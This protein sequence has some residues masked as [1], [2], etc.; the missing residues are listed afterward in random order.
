MTKQLKPIFLNSLTPPSIFT[1]ICLS[2]IGALAM[3]IFLP[4]LPSMAKTFGVTYATATLTITLF[5]AMNAVFQL[6]VGPLSDRFGRRPVVLASLIIF[7]LSSFGCILA[8]S[9]ET[10]LIC[11]LLQ[12]VVVAG[13]VL[14][15]AAIRDMHSQDQAASV[16][17]YV[18]MGMAILPLI[19]P[20]VGGGLEVQFGWIAS[21]WVLFGIGV[22]VFL[23]AYLDMGETNLKLI[24]SSSVPVVFG[25]IAS[26]RHLA[27]APILLT[28]V[29]L[30]L[31]G[32]KYLGSPQPN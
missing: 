1:L 18:T 22:L 14:S 6:F 31:L 28:L 29:V 16:L 7:C 3:N 8:P 25:A 2:A 5:L 21:F 30:P 19:G 32:V 10:F 15:R 26:R 9:F 23:L 20:A 17:G 11:R 27:L 4:S 13:L 12:S 24:Q